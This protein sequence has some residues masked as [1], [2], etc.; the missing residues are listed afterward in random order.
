MSRVSLAKIKFVNA[1]IALC[2]I[3]CSFLTNWAFAKSKAVIFFS[4]VKPLP[5]SNNV[6]S[7]LIEV[8]NGSTSVILASP[9][10][11]LVSLFVSSILFVPLNVNEGL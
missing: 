6:C 2:K 1:S 7:N 3:S 8:V 5:K 9:P 10:L 4:R 11:W